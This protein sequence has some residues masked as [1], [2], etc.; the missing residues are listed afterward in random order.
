MRV[1][2]TLK[3]HGWT[4][5]REGSGDRQWR[6]ERKT[7]AEVETEVGTP[8]AEVGTEVGTPE[9]GTY[10]VGW[11]EVGT[12]QKQTISVSY[13]HPSQPSQPKTYAK[14]SVQDAGSDVKKGG[15]RESGNRLGRWDGWDASARRDFN[16]CSDEPDEEGFDL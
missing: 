5:T 1:A 7:E 16:G 8:P 2:A 9:V 3:A 14:E 4:R 15:Y 6:Y 12:P 13:R 10:G 11:D